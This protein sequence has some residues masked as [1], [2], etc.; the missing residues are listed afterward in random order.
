MVR[1]VALVVLLVSSGLLLSGAG[2]AEKRA[3]PFRIGVL[4]S[5]WGTTPGTIG[6]RDGLLA[7]GYREGEQFEIGVRFTQ[8]NLA[9]LPAAARD[10]V[11]Y[12]VNLIFVTGSD[13]TAKAAQRA[14]S[15]IP[16]VFTDVSD[17]P[18]VGTH[19]ELCP[20]RW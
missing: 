18:R 20:A 15:Q 6:L 19:P 3:Q 8:G 2:P 1:C 11:Q 12:G 4:T 10:L 14:T 5:S 9:E 7:L 13:E 16:I 17:P